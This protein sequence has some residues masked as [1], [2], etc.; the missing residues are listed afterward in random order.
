MLQKGE[1]FGEEELIRPHKRKYSVIC[2]SSTGTLYILKKEEFTKKILNDEKTY[3]IM[4]TQIDSKAEFFKNRIKKFINASK[5]AYASLDLTASIQ[6]EVITDQDEVF[7]LKNNNDIL[8]RP[9][10]QKLKRIGFYDKILNP[11]DV[12]KTLQ[13]S[14]KMKQL[15]FGSG[16]VSPKQMFFILRT[17]ARYQGR[18]DT[19]Q[20][21]ISEKE[22]TTKKSEKSE[23]II[24]EKSKEIPTGK[25]SP[26]KCSPDIKE[27]P[28]TN[29]NFKSVTVLPIKTEDINNFLKKKDFSD[30]LT[31]TAYENKRVKC[32]SYVFSSNKDF[33]KIK[34]NDW[35]CEEKLP[36]SNN[37]K[38]D[39]DLPLKY[40]SNT[41]KNKAKKNLK[42][43]FMES[44]TNNVF[45]KTTSCF[46]KQ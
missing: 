33:K 13:N 3:E 42:K 41:I 44:P 34:L 16:Q 43:Y 7:I 35:S 37:S 24:D 31:P 21:V 28:K 32:K 5:N 18:L 29:V 14:E 25:I 36:F 11:E 15:G 4:K 12:I 10:T 19:K 40:Q 9:P 2:S 8:K 1:Y 39:Y 6:Q 38:M 30:F 20:K 26:F 17:F 23:L 22:Q 46:T 45:F 27:R